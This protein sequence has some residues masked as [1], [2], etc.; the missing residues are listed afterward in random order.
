MVFWNSSDMPM[1]VSAIVQVSITLPLGRFSSCTFR[2][3][4][5]LS[6]REISRMSLINVSR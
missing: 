3:I 5:P 2:L 1:P 6:T 4:L